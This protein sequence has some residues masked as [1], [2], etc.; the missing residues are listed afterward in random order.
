[1]GAPGRN[2]AAEI[3]RRLKKPTEHERCL[4]RPLMPSSSAAASM[5]LPPP[6]ASPAPGAR[7]TL[8]EAGGQ[9]RAARR[10][11]RI[12]FRPRIC[13]SHRTR[14]STLASHGLECG[15]TQRHQHGAFCRRRHHLVL[16]GA[17][18]ETVDGSLSPADK[19]AWTALRQ[20]L[21]GNAAL[22]APFKDMTPPR[23]APRSWRKCL[24]P[25]A[26]RAC[27]PPHGP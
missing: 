18:G 19:A 8:L 9:L 14:H 7:V 6:D 5:A 23:L 20:D 21:L 26:Q 12:W 17:F 3:L 24:G 2:A 10:I 11:L 25:C 15:R 27:S 13:S 22:L 16:K 1:M 4:C